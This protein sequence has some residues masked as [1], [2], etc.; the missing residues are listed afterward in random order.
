MVMKKNNT[1]E[2]GLCNDQPLPSVRV[3]HAGLTEVTYES[4]RL[5]YI[6]YGGWE[7]I[8]MIYPALRDEQWNTIPYVIHDETIEEKDDGFHIFFR[9]QFSSGNILYEANFTVT[10]DRY[11]TISFVMEGKSLGWFIGK[12]IGLCVHHP[13]PAKILPS[14]SYTL[15]EKLPLP[16][17]PV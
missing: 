6:Q 7:V 8:R 11:G 13:L 9:G 14:T 5:R 12:R 2:I 16:V 10:G 4:G 17:F 3:L 15:M 1:E